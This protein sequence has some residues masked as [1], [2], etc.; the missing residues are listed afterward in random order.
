MHALAS[1]L[2]QRVMLSSLQPPSRHLRDSRIYSCK[3]V[4]AYGELVSGSFKVSIHIRLL[5]RCVLV[6]LFA[7]SWLEGNGLWSVP[8]RKGL[9]PGVPDLA[10]PPWGVRA[11]GQRAPPPAGGVVAG[12][13]N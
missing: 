10:R 9:G 13:S 5:L 3:R 11:Y 6:F 8:P 7:T 12:R 4:C 1:S 2:C